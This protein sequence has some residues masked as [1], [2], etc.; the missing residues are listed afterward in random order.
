MQFYKL[1]SCIPVSVLRLD[2]ACGSGMHFCEDMKMARPKAGN[3]III[4]QGYA[5]LITHNGEE[6]ICDIYDLP[7]VA[8]HTWRLSRNPRGYAYGQSHIRQPDGRL[9]SVLLHRLILGFPRLII[10]HRNGNGLDNRRCNLRVASY[11]QNTL[12]SKMRSNNHSGFRGVTW[13]KEQGKWRAQLII[14]RKRINL[15]RFPTKEMAALAYNNAAIIHHGEFAR[16][17]EIDE[18]LL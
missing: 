8:A 11:S 16:L 1:P 5:I 17:N 14:N 6:I 12:N 7:I 15:G 3:E 18:N 9:K 2:N 4:R 10:D 13:D